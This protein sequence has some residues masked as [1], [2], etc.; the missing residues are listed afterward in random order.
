MREQLM[1]A[2]ARAFEDLLAGSIDTS[3]SM[4]KFTSLGCPL[5]ANLNPSKTKFLTSTNKNNNP[6]K[7]LQSSRLNH[8][9]I[10]KSLQEAIT[11][12]TTPTKTP[13]DNLHILGSPV[14]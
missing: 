4:D 14:K 12:Y 8:Q 9:L 1:A 3:R 5:G 2:Y 11:N 13:I 10:G 7:L 6:S